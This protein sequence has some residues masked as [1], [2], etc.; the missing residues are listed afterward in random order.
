[1]NGQ[2]QLAIIGTASLPVGWFPERDDLDAA[3]EVSREAIL[4][5]GIDK[6]EID[7]ILFGACLGNELAE[8]QLTFGRLVD[9]LGLGRNCKVNAQFNA[10]GGT[11]AIMLKAV[12]GMMMAKHVDT[13]L[14]FH[15]QSWSR[16]QTKL[17]PEEL[18]RFFRENGGQYEEWEFPYGMTY[19]A[20]IGL[21]AQRYIYETG[22]T[23]EQIAAAAVSH[24]TWAQL[25]PHARFREP[26]TIEDVLNSR[27][28]ADPLHKFECN[29]L[30]DGASAFILTSAE[31][32]KSG[33]GRKPVYILGE[34]AAGC[35]HFSPV[36]KP[37]KD[38]TRFPGIRP[39]AEKALREAGVKLEDIDIFEAHLAYPVLA[40]MELEEIGFCKRSEAGAF[41]LD[42]NTLPGGKLP[43]STYGESLS[44]GHYGMG[45]VFTALNESVLQLR[46]EAG[47]RQVKDAKLVMYSVGGGAFMVFDFLVLGKELSS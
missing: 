10:G 20:L 30:S 39:A 6:S 18:I 21:L 15:T 3:I 11:S 35:T 34:G 17:S 19:N 38:L 45:C 43:M 9:E 28:I 32:A 33:F 13:V 1:M 40:L 12:R 27:M 26:M 5:A 22:T 14:I 23:P 37:D 2:G 36:Q 16:V 7:G 47:E 31:R 24:R 4:D 46:G 8:C 25:N 29:V 42:G 44:E 41:I